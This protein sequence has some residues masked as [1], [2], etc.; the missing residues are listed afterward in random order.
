MFMK[1]GNLFLCLVLVSILF[2]SG[3]G[4]FAP[5]EKVKTLSNLNKGEMFC[6]SWDKLDIN[7]EKGSNCEMLNYPLKKDN[8]NVDALADCTCCQECIFNGGGTCGDCSSCACGGNGGGTPWYTKMANCIRYGHHNGETY[9]CDH[10]SIQLELDS[11]DVLDPI[12]YGTEELY[13]NFPDQP[14]LRSDP[15]AKLKILDT[16]EKEIYVYM[17]SNRDIAGYQFNLE[18]IE[19]WNADGGSTAENDFVISINPGNPMVLAFSISG[20]V[21][22]AD[23][24]SCS[25]Q[26]LEIG[27]DDLLIKV[28][29]TD[30]DSEVCFDSNSARII[31]DTAGV[32]I[33]GEW[34]DC[35][36]PGSTGCTDEEACNYNPSATID[37]GLCSYPAEDYDCNG[38][39]I[40]ETDCAGI[41]GGDTEIDECGICNGQGMAY[42]T[43][44]CQSDLDCNGTCWGVAVEDGCGVC[45]GPGEIYEC[46]CRNI[47]SWACNC[48]NNVLDCA[49]ECGGNAEV[50]CQGVCGGQ[51]CCEGNDVTDYDG[52]CYG[53]VKIGSQW[54]L[55]SNLRT[56]HY[57]DGT[58]INNVQSSTEWNNM[59]PYTSE[60]AYAYYD[61]D[62][63]N[64]ETHGALYNYNAISNDKGLCPQGWHVPSD[65]EFHE[66]IEYAQNNNGWT[67]SQINDGIPP[68][69]LYDTCG[70]G[71]DGACAEGKNDPSH[72]GDNTVNCWV[73]GDRLKSESSNWID[74]GYCT[75][76]D[77]WSY[78][79]GNTYSTNALGFSA[80]PSGI[81]TGGDFV[82]LGTLAYFAT[83]TLNEGQFA[84]YAHYIYDHSCSIQE[85]YV[86]RNSAT[87][88]RCIKD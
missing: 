10:Y 84:Y 58:S 32:Q 41:C 20:D 40:A 28:S 46:G 4:N 3:C 35:F 59:D 86:Q 18:G 25:P 48:N 5:N 2:I 72:E 73:S 77:A 79:Y 21:I 87:S 75:S 64:S 14:N 80:E 81:R 33:P 6:E 13:I 26:E 43:G 8:S 60:G 15:Y 68:N 82:N 78:G 37:N 53:K 30:I 19:L 65:G 36:T 12:Y 44:C 62:E 49:G 11:Y 69:C 51:V 61:N 7:H 76:P 71:P 57:R 52:N 31:S 70:P 47:Y 17:V 50:N 38:N 22:P 85:L 55:T 88:V 1:R 29:Y 34:G 16:S 9:V 63:S 42:G 74:S 27:D 39:C 23:C 54:W 45:D 24:A 66:L 56:T 67:C 83:S